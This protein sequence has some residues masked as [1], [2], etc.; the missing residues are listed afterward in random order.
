MDGGTG[1]D[2][3]RW[4]RVRAIFDDVAALDPAARPARLTALCGSDESLRH[5]VASL[6]A[7]DAGDHDDDPIE[8]TVR[9]AAREAAAASPEAGRTL[10]HYRLT[11]PLGRGGMGIVWKAVDET[12][13]RDVAIKVLPP[14][15][16]DDTRRLSRFEREAKV[17]AS[18]NHANIAGIFGMH[19]LGSVRFLA[20]EYVPGEDLARRLARGPITVDD[21]LRIAHQIA[22]ALE[23]AHERGVVHRDLKP[24]NIKLTPG[25]R[26]KVLDFGLAKAFGDEPPF[27]D[28][29]T[30][31]SSD[32]VIAQV[33]T[34][35][36]VVLGTAAY[37]PPEQAR[38]LPVDKRADIW[39]F[40][41]VLYEMLA[42]VRPF[43][44]ATTVDLFAAVVTAEPDWARLP[45]ATPPALVAL[46]RRCLQKDARQR[47]RDIGDALIELAHLL[48]PP[49][50]VASVMTLVPP[51]ARRGFLWAAAIAATVLIG[52]AAFWLGRQ[53]TPSPAV[54]AVRTI[55]VLPLVDLS[56][57]A[58][59]D[60]FV[61]GL[62]VE[63]L[64]RLAR[65]PRLRVTAQ[66]S[67]F[68]FRNTGQDLRAVA[69][70]LG[71]SALLEGSVR[72]SGRNIRLTAQ[73]VD[74]NDG[75]HLWSGTYDREMGDLLVVQDEIARAVA[76]AM[77]VALLGPGPARPTTRPSGP[78]Y[79]AYLQGHH[80]RGLNS[81]ESLPRAVT[82]F[83]EAVR[84]DPG[85]APAWAGLSRTRSTM[86]AE[87]FAR[88]EAEMSEARRSAERA[89]AL[90]P[91]LADGHLALAIV[92]RAYDWDWAGADASTQRALQ[93]EPNNADIVFGAARMASTLGRVDEALALTER[94]ATLD[95]LNV[96]VLY[97]LGRYQQFL[98]QLDAAASS[99]QRTL[100]LAP[101]YPAGH[102]SLALVRLAQSRVDDALAEL[103][104][105]PLEYWRLHGEAVA[106][107][108][109]GRN[110]EADAALKTFI[111]R[112][113]DIGPLQIAQLYAL[114]GDAAS[115]V[116]WLD[117]AYVARDSGLSQLK[118]TAYFDRI[119]GDPRYLTFL[120][121]MHLPH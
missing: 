96:Q 84:L 62:T 80:F 46:L 118:S 16:G 114:R 54:A 47:L 77:Q 3:A 49:A 90:D 107:H 69:R 73:L 63:L 104:L 50:P 33:T 40:G 51:P 26:V 103:R 29:A 94:A 60:N 22:E 71:V 39:A 44:G 89:I 120:D 64:G 119:A 42:G 92:Q 91:L 18:L 30:S 75:L 113:A 78:A 112:H 37:M 98:G 68:Q 85:F 24:A 6:L 66:T 59:A 57:G 7:H 19:E 35:E 65:N 58:D 117:R 5:E 10:L 28:E 48:A 116:T 12:L 99:L 41:V 9:D 105:E 61:D 70:T 72:R 97:R 95:P 21:T 43:A 31:T 32:A 11:E 20:M 4:R 53:S 86:A 106:F 55:A 17:L 121:R 88:P 82:F 87:G 81:R 83:E 79:T 27:S 8:R 111:A 25:G 102:S 56:P 101:D 109:L 76:E 52:G 93:L 67:A 2:L 100:A 115:S 23:E 36:G 34:R 14:G 1:D 110:G 108:V 45:S 15:I 38:G 13:G 74:A